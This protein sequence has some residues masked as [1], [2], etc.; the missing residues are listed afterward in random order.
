MLEQGNA[1]GLAQRVSHAGAKLPGTKPF[2]Q[3]EQQDLVAMIREPELGTPSTFFTLSSADIQWPD[4]HRHMPNY[5]EEENAQSYRTHM[6][7]LNNNPTI[8]AYYF[9]KCWQIF[10]EEVMVPKFNII[11][12]WWRYEWQHQGSS[13]IHGFFWLKNAPSPD[14]LD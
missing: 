13:H 10:F 12:W 3:H 5:S 4:M 6:N 14:N 11:D 2:W 9:Q 7:D 8:A 1:D